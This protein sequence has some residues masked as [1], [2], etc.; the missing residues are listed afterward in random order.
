MQYPSAY[1][2]VATLSTAAIGLVNHLGALGI[3]VGVFLNGLGIPGLSEVLLPLGG[4]AVHQGRISLPWLFVVAMVCQLAGLTVAYCLARF[5]GLAL[6]EK[7]GKYLLVSSRDLRAAHRAFVKHGGGLVIVGAFTPGIQGFIG[8][9]AGIAEMN[10]IRF[11]VAALVGKLVWIGG[12]LYLGSVLGNRIDMV[13]Q[14]LKQAAL[15]I[16][17]A[18]AALVAWHIWGHSRHRSQHAE[19]SGKENL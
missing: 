4:V 17:V 7:Y 12:L 13:Q 11:I 6:V 15:I 3:G 14:S 19:E 9:V 2:I 10:Y 18:A 8:Y 1:F 5:G 16:L